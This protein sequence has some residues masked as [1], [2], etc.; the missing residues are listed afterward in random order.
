ML[1]WKGVY[2][3]NTLGGIWRGSIRLTPLARDTDDDGEKFGLDFP[4]VKRAKW[5]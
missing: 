4:E 3:I 2:T 1:R 5:V